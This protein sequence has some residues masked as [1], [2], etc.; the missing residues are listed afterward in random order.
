MS[1]SLVHNI[2]PPWKVWS[3]I[4]EFKCDTTC[5]FTTVHMWCFG[6]VNHFTFAMTSMWQR[7]QQ[8][9]VR[10]QNFWQNDSIWQPRNDNGE[11]IQHTVPDFCAWM[12]K[13]SNIRV[14]HWSTIWIILLQNQR[15]KDQKSAFCCTF[16][17]YADQRPHFRCSIRK[18]KLITCV[19]EWHLLPLNRKLGKHITI[20]AAERTYKTHH[21]ITPPAFVRCINT[22]LYS[23]FT[24]LPG[25]Q[26]NMSLQGSFCQKVAMTM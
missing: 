4:S 21:H 1:V 22:L 14:A 2:N 25:E 24:Q 9:S 6:S 5:F 8:L 18:V 3:W 10:I 16:P 13:R 19:V 23:Q 26:G 20:M 7:N 11:D 15:Q 17:Y 12:I